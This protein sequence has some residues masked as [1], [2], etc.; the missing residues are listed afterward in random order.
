M[1][2]IEND[3][4]SI[5][6]NRQTMFGETQLLI[7]EMSTPFACMSLSSETRSF[8]DRP[9]RSTLDAATILALPSAAASIGYSGTGWR[10]S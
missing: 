9:S 2:E 3:F 8:S 1:P 7:Q 6:F 10:G 4:G 5:L